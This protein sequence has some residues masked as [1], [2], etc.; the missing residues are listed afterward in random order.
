[1]M[2]TKI[3]LMLFTLIIALGI[4]GAVSATDGLTDKNCNTNYQYDNQDNWNEEDECNEKYN[5]Q[6][7][8][9]DNAGYAEPICDKCK[10]YEYK[11]KCKEEVK[12][13]PCKSSEEKCDEKPRYDPCKKTVDKYDKKRA[14]CK[15]AAVGDRVWNDLNANGIQDANEP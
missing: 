11:C 5:D 7:Y 12:Y 8:I 3:A 14:P 1:M 15:K 13:D 2:K 4:A 9:K 10:N 6:D